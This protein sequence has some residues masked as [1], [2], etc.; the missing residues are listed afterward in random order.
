VR[1]K[2]GHPDGGFIALGEPP[3]GLVTDGKP[4]VAMQATHKT[5]YDAIARL[6]PMFPQNR[7]QD[8]IQRKNFTLLNMIAHLPA[9]RTR[10]RKQ[11]HALRYDLRLSFHVVTQQRARFIR[12][13]DI[14]RGEV[15][16]SVMPPSG[17]G[18]MKDRLSWH[19]ITAERST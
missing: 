2:P 14:I 7:V 9:Q 11:T 3:I 17:R 12:L 8:H 18:R 5:P 16:M 10:R 4:P 15:T 1:Q 13:P 6:A 19:F